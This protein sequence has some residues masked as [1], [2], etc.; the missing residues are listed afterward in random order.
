MKKQKDLKMW[1]N[2]CSEK[3]IDIIDRLYI[4]S[5]FLLIIN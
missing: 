2:G 4:Y 3:L 1:K 5:Y